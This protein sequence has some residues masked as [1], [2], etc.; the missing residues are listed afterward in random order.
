MTITAM[1]DVPHGTRTD[2]G[3]TVG[4]DRVPA[5]LL[6]PA[7]SPARAPVVLLLHGLTSRKERMADSVGSALLKK[8]V[9][10]LAIDLPM[11][12]DRD[13]DVASL[14]GASPLALVSVWRSAMSEVRAALDLL[15]AHAGVDGRRIGIVGYSL[16][17]YLALAAAADQPAIR[18]VALAAGGDLPERTPFAPLVRTV[19]DPPR[20]VRQLAGRPLLMVSGTRDR[21]VTPAQA[22]R[23]FDAA[24]EPKT[25]RWYD[26]GHWPPP[27]AINATAKWVAA[28]LLEPSARTARTTAP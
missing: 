12:G 27:M 6:R 3:L 24:L 15:E 9:A 23:L 7:D 8:G 14:R 1:R 11:H 13:G 2:L 18:C 5:I 26:G 28:C 16:G 17:S 20:M 25:M 4:R 22:T 19:L 10:S 21:T